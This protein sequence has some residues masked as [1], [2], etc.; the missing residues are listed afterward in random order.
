MPLIPYLKNLCLLSH[1]R[2]AASWVMLRSCL[3]MG[4]SFWAGR[5]DEVTSRGPFQSHPFSD[6]VTWMCTVGC[7]TH[8]VGSMI[9]VC[10]FMAHTEGCPYWAF[11][12][13]C[14]SFPLGMCLFRQILGIDQWEN[15]IQSLLYCSSCCYF[16]VLI[17]RFGNSHHNPTS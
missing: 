9:T 15:G 11:F 6:C 5:L 10:E 4:G 8:T 3:E 7:P 1:H 17:H 16:T 12:L 13:H 2:A 14:F